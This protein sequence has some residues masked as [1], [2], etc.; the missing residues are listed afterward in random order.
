MQKKKAGVFSI[1]MSDIEIGKRFLA[2]NSGFSAVAAGEQMPA[3]S[4]LF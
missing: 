1:E 2:A 3:L 4:F